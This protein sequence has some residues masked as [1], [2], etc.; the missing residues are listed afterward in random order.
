M[1]LVANNEIRSKEEVVNVA[2]TLNKVNVYD[3][4]RVWGNA[5]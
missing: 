2:K 5:R 1:M 3:Q 4:V